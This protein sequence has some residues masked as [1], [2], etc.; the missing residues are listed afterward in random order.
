MDLSL[1]LYPDQLPS[2]IVVN[3]VAT[4]ALHIYRWRLHR[5][6]TCYIPLHVSAAIKTT[7]GR[8]ISQK[9]MSSVL[10]QFHNRLICCAM[11]M[12]SVEKFYKP[13][14]FSSRISFEIFFMPLIINT[15]NQLI[16]KLGTISAF[17]VL[18]TIIF[19]LN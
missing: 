2:L 1:R 14:A 8:H 17:C 5:P 4:C 3:F 11:S 18:N 16:K 12:F 9:A 13:L 10:Q 6:S 7:T 19:I 15:K